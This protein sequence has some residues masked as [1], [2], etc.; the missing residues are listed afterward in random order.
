MYD[1]NDGEHPPPI[2]SGSGQL[3]IRRIPVLPLGRQ[4]CMMLKQ[5]VVGPLKESVYR[6]HSVLLQ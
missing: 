1:N 4:F 5:F 3:T 2:V 6:H